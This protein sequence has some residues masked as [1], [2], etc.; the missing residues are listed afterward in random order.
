LI[1]LDCLLSRTGHE[2]VFISG[3]DLPSG[4][5]RDYFGSPATA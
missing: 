5:I 3:A 1:F 2:E 4:L